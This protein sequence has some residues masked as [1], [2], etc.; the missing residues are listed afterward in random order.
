M[1]KYLNPTV[2]TSITSVQIN[3]EDLELIFKSQRPGLEYFKI[4]KSSGLYNTVL[5]IFPQEFRSFIDNSCIVGIQSMDYRF[6]NYLHTDIPNRFYAI[7]Y[8][9]LTGGDPVYTTTFDDANQ[10]M[11]VYNVPV[12]TWY[13]LSTYTLNKVDGITGIRTEL[14]ISIPL[15]PN[16][17]FINWLNSVSITV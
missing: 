16:P 14:S 6:N 15:E 8:T 1:L 10:N 13:S 3:P 7:N 12:H 11:Q 2:F 9:F 4:S 5:N 17:D